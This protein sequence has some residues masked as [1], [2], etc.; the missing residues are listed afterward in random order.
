MR[1]PPAFS[2]HCRNLMVSRGVRSF[3]RGKFP[4][5]LA[6]GKMI[7]LTKALMGF[8]WKGDGKQKHTK[9]KQ[10]QQGMGL[11]GKFLRIWKRSRLHSSLRKP[12]NSSSGLPFSRRQRNLLQDI[13]ISMSIPYSLA[14]SISFAPKLQSRRNPSNSAL[15]LRNLEI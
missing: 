14:P 6:A 7:A 10:H 15:F 5:L 4:S 8:G 3:C 9:I 12:Q 13:G 1:E 2:V 11:R